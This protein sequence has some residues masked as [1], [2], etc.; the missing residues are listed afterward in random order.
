M[1]ARL[2][3]GK[4]DHIVVLTDLEREPDEAAVRQRITEQHTP[5]IFV[6]VKALEAWFLA[7]TTAMCRW[8]KVDTFHE[9]APEATPGMPWDHL[10]T[11]AQQHQAR[12]PGPSKVLF[13]RNFCDRQGYQLARAAS[14]GA[15]PSARA[16]HDALIGLAAPAA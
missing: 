2:A 4:P 12:G 11:V 10:R 9:P 8:L 14:H 16:F 5:L 3:V 1:V 6:A 13:A 15:C 7:D